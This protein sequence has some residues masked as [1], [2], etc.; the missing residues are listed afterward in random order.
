MDRIH[1]YPTTEKIG[2]LQLHYIWHVFDQIW[3]STSWP[4][5]ER[6]SLS[7][8]GISQ[9]SPI[10][11]FFTSWASLYHYRQ[12]HTVVGRQTAVTAHFKSRQLLSFPFACQHACRLEPDEHWNTI[13]HPWRSILTIGWSRV[14]SERAGCCGWIRVRGFNA[15]FYVLFTN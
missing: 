3:Q 6:L 15:V 14:R 10:Q 1:P 4:I 7:R 9:S 12:I 8:A 5:R 13:S 2:G 11:F